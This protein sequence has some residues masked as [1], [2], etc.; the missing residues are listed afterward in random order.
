MAGSSLRSLAEW[1][2]AAS[3]TSRKKL[4]RQRTAATAWTDLAARTFAGSQAV[5]SDAGLICDQVRFG[6]YVPH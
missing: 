2:T 3:S 1:W 4:V 5:R 6:A